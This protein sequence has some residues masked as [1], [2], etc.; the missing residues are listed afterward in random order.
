VYVA[1]G[2]KDQ[3][4]IVF[5]QAREFV[6][7]SPRLSD[8]LQV[9]KNVITC[10][11]NNG[12]FRVLAAEAGTN[13]GLNPSGVVIDEL[14]VHKDPELY[15]SL[16]TGQLAREAPL[17]VSITTAGFDRETIC[18]DMYERGKELERQGLSAMRD[19]G[20]YFKWYE[21]DEKASVHDLEGWQAANPSSWIKAKDLAREADR[22]PENI[23]RR[24]HLNQWTESEEAWITPAQWDA[25]EGTPQIDPS[26]PLIC[27]ADDIGFKRDAAAI[28][29]GQWRDDN[30]LHVGHDIMVPEKQGEVFGP[31][32]IRGRTASVAK[33]PGGVREIAYDP[34]QFRESAEILLEAGLPMVEYPQSSGRMAP[35]SENLYELI[36][37]QRIV[38]DGDRTL[39]RHVL[40][41]VAGETDRG[42]WRISKRKSLERIDGCIA[43]AM[44]ADRAVTLRYEKPPSK[45]GAF[46]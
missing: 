46:L 36:T 24:L 33:N 7:A 6:Q 39:R 25:C 45:R 16:T 41:A 22:L 20:F 23:F 15:Y 42:G 9:Q 38:H 18:W 3:A 31:A 35:A 28:V 8:W 10:K 21:A 43:L 19:S 14:H 34:W 27:I 29:W 2:S 37:H 44:M 17:V 40:S 4:R 32:D 11:S 30:R 12:V 26:L 5:N 13:Y 1:A